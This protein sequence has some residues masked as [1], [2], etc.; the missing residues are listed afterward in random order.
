MDH[1]SDYRS[2]ASVALA[3]VVGGLLLLMGG[4]HFLAVTDLARAEGR[5][6]DFH[7]VSTITMSAIIALPGILSLAL[8]PWLWRARSWAYAMV[9]AASICLFG[10][11]LLLFQMEKAD[12]PKVGDELDMAIAAVALYIVVTSGLWIRATARGPALD[13]RTDGRATPPGP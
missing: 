13:A 8:M 4:G 9:I 12:P 7:F 11:L 1:R 10:Y 6:F 2:P 3:V 5:P